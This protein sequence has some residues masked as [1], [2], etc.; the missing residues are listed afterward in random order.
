MY[1]NAEIGLSALA[2]G[3]PLDRSLAIAGAFELRPL[4]EL[5]G[6]SVHVLN[7]YQV[8]QRVAGCGRVELEGGRRYLAQLADMFRGAREDRESL[9]ALRAM[10][11]AG[12]PGTGVPM[13]VEAGER[14]AA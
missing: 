7:A 11:A 10:D 3:W 8:L 1:R 12:S 4:A 5:P 9:A 2:S 6:A 14:E 13:S